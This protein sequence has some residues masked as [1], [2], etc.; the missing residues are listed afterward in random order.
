MRA[1]CQKS[2]LPPLPSTSPPPLPPAR[3]LHRAAPRRP[4]RSAGGRAAA[5]GGGGL[6]RPE[7]R[8]GAD[9]PGA[10]NKSGTC[11]CGSAAQRAQR[12]RA[13]GGC[14]W[15]Q[16]T[17]AVAC[18]WNAVVRRERPL[19]CCG[20]GRSLPLGRHAGPW[21]AASPC[22]H[23][24][25][26]EPASKP[27]KKQSKP[28]P[29]APPP[30]APAPAPAPPPAQQQP[31]PAQ[32]LLEAARRGDADAVQ[33]LV[34]EGADV[35]AVDALGRTALHHAAL[36]NHVDLVGVLLS[37]GRANVAAVD[38]NLYTPCHLAAAAG[39][40]G[41]LQGLAWAAA[42][43]SPPCIDAATRDG[44]TALHVS[45]FPAWAGLRG[46]PCTAAPRFTCSAEPLWLYSTLLAMTS[47]TAA[48]P[49][50]PTDPSDLT[51]APSLPRLLP[52]PRL[53]RSWRQPTGARPWRL[54]CWA[55]APPRRQW[56][57]TA[58]LPCTYS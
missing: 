13:A 53:P 5:A 49:P 45:P 51:P 9:G 55:W 57:G 29:A 56:T 36:H 30:A 33:E 46:L 14:R 1:T 43:S 44:R 6:S 54:H 21:L 25:P 4:Q 11:S 35:N 39:H 15:A 12:R 42:S 31:S 7:D 16:V 58:T 47:G 34:L 32:L 24:R 3:R 2:P 38:S 17:S 27:P 10:G 8:T 23:L 37:S 19:N 50:Q 40:L 41:P 52:S 26:G 22:P 18:A 28:K 48:A 20:S